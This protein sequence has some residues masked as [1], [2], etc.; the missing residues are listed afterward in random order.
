MLQTCGRLEIYA[1]LEEYEA[2]S[3]Q[4]K[5]FLRNFRHGDVDVDM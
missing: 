2:G 5:T 1:E 3:E 4:L